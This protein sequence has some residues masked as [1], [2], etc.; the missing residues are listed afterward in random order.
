MDGELDMKMLQHWKENVK[1]K[2]IIL[3]IPWVSMVIQ[4]RALQ[5]RPRAFG[6]ST[7]DQ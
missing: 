2:L 6:T 7:W 5:Q 1:V 3:D 4:I